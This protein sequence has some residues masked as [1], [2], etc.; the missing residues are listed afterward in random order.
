[1]QQRQVIDH[2]S[3]RMRAGDVP[4]LLLGQRDELLHVF[5]AQVGV[6]DQQHGRLAHGAQLLEVG[7]LVRQ[8][9]VEQGVQD[10]A[11][12]AGEAQCVPIGLRARHRHRG[13]DGLA[14]GAVFHDHALLERLA[15]ALGQGARRNVG[16]AAG[17]KAHQQAHGTRREGVLGPGGTRDQG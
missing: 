9:V 16:Q 4:G 5:H 1:M 3:P 14:A 12:G 6:H 15:H 11:V 17:G 10:H 7:R 8:V 2:P 13:N